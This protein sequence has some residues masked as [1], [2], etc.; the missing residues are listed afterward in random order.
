MYSLIDDINKTIDATLKASPLENQVL[1][2]VSR[3]L[4]DTKNFITSFLQFHFK[5][6]DH[7]FN[8]YYYMI[9]VQILKLNLKMLEDL[10]A[11]SGKKD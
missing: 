7:T 8:L 5:N 4:T 9:V 10:P 1:A 11:L 2:Q 6:N 3:N